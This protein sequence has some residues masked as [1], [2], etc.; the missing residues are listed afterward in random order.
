MLGHDKAFALYFKGVLFRPLELQI[1]GPLIPILHIMHRIMHYNL[2]IIFL[3]TFLFLPP[4]TAN[5]VLSNE[6]EEVEEYINHYLYSY[7]NINKEKDN[8]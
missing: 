6:L 1:K 2:Q 7:V 5:N 3:T 4:Q 8:N